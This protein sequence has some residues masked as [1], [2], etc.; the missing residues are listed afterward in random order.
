MNN[1]DI[2]LNPK[3]KRFEVKN[4]GE[5]MVKASQ[6]VPAPENGVEEEE[7]TIT[8]EIDGLLDEGW[9]LG[10]LVKAGYARSTVRMRIR[11]RAKTNPPLP[12]N[13]GENGNHKVSLT[14]K[15]KETVLPEWLEQQVG[16]L[17]DGDE[18]TRKIFMAG[19]SIP[20]L[21]MRLFSESFK[22]LL[23][24]M[25]ANTANQAEV[26]RSLQGGSEEVAK[27]TIVEAMPYLER[28]VRENAIATSPDPMKAM[29]VRAIEPI[30]SNTISSV[31]GGMFKL[32]GQQPQGQGQSL[33]TGWQDT[34]KG[35]Q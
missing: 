22:P 29:V 9:S 2:T 17:Y 34:T 21:G 26:A 35:G 31:M 13:G 5:A 20:L 28:I 15:D 24:L 1:N 18:K 3:T 11:K 7:A 6:V 4:G 27:S 16:E 19:M 30:F 14:V 8:Q 33:P 23:A 32:P 10:R 12:D 25:Q